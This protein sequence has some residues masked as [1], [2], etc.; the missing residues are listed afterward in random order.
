VRTALFV[1]FEISLRI[2][3]RKSSLLCLGNLLF[4]RAPRKRPPNYEIYDE[5]DF[6]RV[7]EQNASLL[8]GFAVR[9]LQV[10]DSAG[11]ASPFSSQINGESA[12]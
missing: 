12:A 6:Y 4:L 7:K 8:R 9:L 1:M 10:P 2:V 5:I 11:L 3:N